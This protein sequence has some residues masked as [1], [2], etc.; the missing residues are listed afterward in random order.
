M[1]FSLRARPDIRNAR[2]VGIITY[3]IAMDAAPQR[4]WSGEKAAPI[5]RFWAAARLPE[6]LAIDVPMVVRVP[7]TSRCAGSKTAS[8]PDLASRAKLTKAGCATARERNFYL[9]VETRQSAQ[10]QP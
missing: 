1:L 6:K 2:D 8:V 9:H 5:E 10:S 7:R 4:P 3:T